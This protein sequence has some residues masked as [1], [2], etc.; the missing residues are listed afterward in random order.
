[1]SGDDQW[2]SSATHLLDNVTSTN[3]ACLP[4]IFEAQEATLPHDACTNAPLRVPETP[5]IHADKHSCCGNSYLYVMQKLF[6]LAGLI[7]LS[8]CTFETDTAAP[9]ASHP[10]QTV[11]GDSVPLSE[12]HTAVTPVDRA[13]LHELSGDLET[14]NGS[15]F[16]VTY[17]AE[18]AAN[19]LAP[20]DSIPDYTFVQTDE[21][22]FS[23]RD[24]A[25]EFYVYSPQW[26][27]TSNYLLTMAGEQ[28]MGTTIDT[29]VTAD[30][31]PKHCLTTHT[32]KG[33]NG[34]YYRSYQQTETESTTVVFGV[35]YRDSTV[36]NYYEKAYQSFVNSLVQYAD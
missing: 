21:A 8:A 6:L 35:K 20:V 14:Y 12:K 34:Q 19:P 4:K 7:G 24:G 15:W 1:M 10:A 36:M 25:I 28:V 11:Q 17:P 9:M 2:N 27:G 31:Q 5:E 26:S 29:I 3:A 23:S 18:F 16:T 13:S 33:E 32:W 30:D 22:S